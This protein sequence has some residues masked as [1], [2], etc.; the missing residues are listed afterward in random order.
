MDGQ[1]ETLA[2]FPWGQYVISLYFAVMTF[3]TVGYGDIHPINIYEHYV[4]ILMMLVGG[5]MWA[6]LIGVLTQIVQ[7]MDP[8]NANFK[9]VAIQS[10]TAIFSYCRRS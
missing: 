9:K 1:P 10:N 8:H 3:C 6:Y 4:N 2:Y 7:G 5:V